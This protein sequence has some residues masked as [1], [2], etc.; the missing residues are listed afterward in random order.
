MSDCRTPSYGVADAD[1]ILGLSAHM[2]VVLA[3]LREAVSWTTTSREHGP[4]RDALAGVLCGQGIIPARRGRHP[5]VQHCAKEH[6][7]L[8]LGRSSKNLEAIA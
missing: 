2:V 1:G 8:V 6:C 4:P 3:A 7:P 5:K